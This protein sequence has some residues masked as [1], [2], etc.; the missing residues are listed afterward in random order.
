MA[1]TIDLATASGDAHSKPFLKAAVMGVAT[2]PGLIVT[3][4]SVWSRPS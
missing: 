1:C 3:T 2:K 4:V